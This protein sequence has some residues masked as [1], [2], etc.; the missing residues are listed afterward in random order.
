MYQMYHMFNKNVTISI[1]VQIWDFWRLETCET[2][3]NTEFHL[4]STQVNDPKILN[5]LQALLFRYAFGRT[6]PWPR[7]CQNGKNDIEKIGCE[8]ANN[9]LSF[10]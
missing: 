1:N 8:I 7:E 2:F 9:R 4:D 6:C 3:S 10:V 5:V